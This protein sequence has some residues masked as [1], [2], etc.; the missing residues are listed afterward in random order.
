MLPFGLMGWATAQSA[1]VPLSHSNLLLTSN[2]SLPTFIPRLRPAPRREDGGRQGGWHPCVCVIC[3]VVL[4]VVVWFFFVWPCFS[5]GLYASVAGLSSLTPS[6]SASSLSKVS[7]C[8][9][10][11]LILT[12]TLTPTTGTWRLRASDLPMGQLV[13]RCVFHLMPCKVGGRRAG[14]D[15]MGQKRP[16][17]G[18]RGRQTVDLGPG[19]P[20]TSSDRLGGGVWR[21]NGTRQAR[22]WTCV[23][24]PSLYASSMDLLVRDA[25]L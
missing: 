7:E 17:D 9:E 14:Y 19:G 3:V 25:E 20:F 2:T 13:S 12:L 1:S 22:V 24:A 8:C 6:S 11:S 10:C 21:G 5:W 23:A 16:L 15:R 18:R 4:G